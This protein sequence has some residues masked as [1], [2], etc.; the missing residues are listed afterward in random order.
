MPNCD[1]DKVKRSV[2]RDISIQANAIRFR[3]L[4]DKIN[5]CDLELHVFAYLDD[6]I[7]A[8]NTFDEHVT[9]LKEVAKILG[10]LC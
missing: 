3:R 9:I 10:Q 6:L 7:V 8:T 4:M 1:N 5:G 2:G